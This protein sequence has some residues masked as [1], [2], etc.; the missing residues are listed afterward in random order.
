M[1]KCQR[2]IAQFGFKLSDKNKTFG[3][4]EELYEHVE[5]VHGVIVIRDG[6]TEEKAKERCAQKGI[7]LDR[8][9]CA[10][11]ECKILRGEQSSIRVADYEIAKQWLGLPIN[12]LD[13]LSF[14]K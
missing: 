9:K 12:I 14:H 11:E 3:T 8:T 4:D 5:N 13:L 1:K 2:C 6:E 7:L 10:C